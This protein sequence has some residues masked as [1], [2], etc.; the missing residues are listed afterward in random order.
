VLEILD[1][2]AVRELRLARPPVNALNAELVAALRAA[3][4]SAQAPQSGVR[5]IVLSGQP[6][7]FSAG[8]DVRALAGLDAAGMR[9]FIVEFTALQQELAASR[10]P[11]IAAITGHCPAGGTVLALFCDYRIMARGRFSIGLNEVQVG[12]YPGEVIMRAFERLVGPRRSADLLTRGALLDPEA[13]LA[14]GLVDELADAT[15]VRERALAYAGELLAL[16]PN[17]Y[18]R[19]RALV[20]RDLVALFDGSREGLVESFT[21][22]FLSAETRSQMM[23]VLSKGGADRR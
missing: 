2:G 1:D 7:L 6:G 21:E 18:A 3:L 16:P 14:S 4:Q 13:A 23:A 5:A 22:M 12:L 20:R 10:V 19:T 15:G 17:A 8:L 11:V 9:S